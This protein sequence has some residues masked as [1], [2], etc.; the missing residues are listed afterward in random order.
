MQQGR[1][2]LDTLSDLIGLSVP[3]ALEKEFDSCAV[4]MNLDSAANKEGCEG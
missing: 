2:E 3:L 4:A 1:Q